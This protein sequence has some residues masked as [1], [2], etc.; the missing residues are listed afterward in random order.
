MKFKGKLVSLIALILSALL[1]FSG[2]SILAKNKD[3]ETEYASEEN[4]SEDFVVESVYYNQGENLVDMNITNAKPFKDGYAYL[5]LEDSIETK[6]NAIT[7]NNGN[8]TFFQEQAVR[9]EYRNSN[10]GYFYF[11]KND[12]NNGYIISCIKYN[13][14]EIYEIELPKTDTVVS[15]TVEDW[16]DDGTVVVSR[17]VTSFDVNKVEIAWIGADGEYS[18]DWHEINEEEYEIGDIYY[19]EDGFAF[20]TTRNQHYLLDMNIGEFF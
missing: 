16:G 5:C 13:G 8:I 11:Q 9:G 1:I 19:C 4:A 20:I 12:G 10:D 17:N 3:A 2:C 18:L 15:Y 6:Y 7:D 14:E